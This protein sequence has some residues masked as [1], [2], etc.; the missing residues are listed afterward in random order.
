MTF[1]ITAIKTLT[2]VTINNGINRTFKHFLKIIIDKRNNCCYT[3][4]KF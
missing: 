4:D 1:N 2:A 3:L